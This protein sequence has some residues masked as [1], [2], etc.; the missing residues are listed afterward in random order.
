[1]ATILRRRSRDAKVCLGQG[2]P[3][4]MSGIRALTGMADLREVLKIV[5]RELR[6]TR[7]KTGVDDCGL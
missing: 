2:S 5:C 3:S 1:M 4:I 6:P 7:T